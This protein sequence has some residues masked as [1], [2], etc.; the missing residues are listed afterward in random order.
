V[1]NIIWCTG[2]SPGFSWIK[3]PIFDAQ[4]EPLHECGIVD[5]VPGMYFVGLHYLYAMSSA[6]IIGVS[7]DA[8]RVVK[9]I[10]AR[11]RVPVAA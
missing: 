8:E 1:R 10:A 9:A 7:R 6:T 11:S 4:G 5:R 3:L 2:Y